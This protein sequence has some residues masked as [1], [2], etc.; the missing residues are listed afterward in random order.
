MLCASDP[1][2]AWGGAR[3]LRDEYGHHARRGD[4]GPATDN[5]VGTGQIESRLGLPAINALTNGAAL[6]DAVAK[7]AGIAGDDAA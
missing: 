6:G 4:P 7:A 2:A 3:L 1:V 5:D